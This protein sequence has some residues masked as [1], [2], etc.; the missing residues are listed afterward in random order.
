MS[1]NIGIILDIFNKLEK[2]DNNWIQFLKLSKRVDGFWETKYLQYYFWK[3]LA[4]FFCKI[5]VLKN[6]IIKFLWKQTSIFKYLQNLRWYIA[7]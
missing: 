3:G 4:N 7:F 1:V 6:L 5:N 2:D